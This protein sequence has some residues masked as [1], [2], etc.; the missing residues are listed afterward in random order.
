MSGTVSPER[1]DA[2]E[3]L[4]WL[5]FTVL[6]LLLVLVVGFVSLAS[7]AMT[8]FYVVGGIALVLASLVLPAWAIYGLDETRH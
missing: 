6:S 5:T 7:G 3:W 4:G 1:S 8:T 2:P